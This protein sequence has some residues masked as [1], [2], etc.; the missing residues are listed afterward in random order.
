M[1]EVGFEGG[2]DGKLEEMKAG[3]HSIVSFLIWIISIQF[4]IEFDV[5]IEVLCSL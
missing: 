3:G 5:L 1:H 4:S 2:I